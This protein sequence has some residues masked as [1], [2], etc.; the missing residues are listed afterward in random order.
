MPQPPTASDRL[1]SADWC[2]FNSLSRFFVED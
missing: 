1:R 2:S